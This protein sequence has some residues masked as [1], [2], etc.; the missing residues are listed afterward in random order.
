[1]AAPNKKRMNNTGTG[2]PKATKESSPF[3]AVFVEH[4]LVSSS[5]KTQINQTADQP[6]LMPFLELSA[7]SVALAALRR[8]P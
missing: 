1:M 8:D 2:T 3:F 5:V 6:P 7:F 4:F